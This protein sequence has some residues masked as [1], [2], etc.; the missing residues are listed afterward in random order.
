MDDDL[1]QLGLDLS[2][3]MMNLPAMKLASLV[4]A[5][6]MLASVAK[7][8]HDIGSDIAKRARTQAGV[9]ATLLDRV[10]Q[11]WELR[12]NALDRVRAIVSQIK[13][14]PPTP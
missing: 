6:S 1:Q 12:D 5:A 4:N 7:I 13:N 8:A 11:V 14:E 9:D 3:Q 2:A 10:A